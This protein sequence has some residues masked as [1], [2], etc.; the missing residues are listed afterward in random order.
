MCGLHLNQK[1]WFV[2]WPVQFIN[3]IAAVGLENYQ[4]Y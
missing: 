2:V 1:A 3:K 4:L